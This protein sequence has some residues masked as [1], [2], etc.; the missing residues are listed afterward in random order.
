MTP[1]ERLQTALNGLGLK[2]IEARLESDSPSGALRI[3]RMSRDR[4]R[5]CPV[6]LAQG[7]GAT[8]LSRSRLLSKSM[9]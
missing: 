1:I 2:A 8:P 5:V 7:D 9:G 6:P 3:L 4:S